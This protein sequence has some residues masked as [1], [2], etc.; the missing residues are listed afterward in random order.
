M[1]TYK[2]IV[3]KKADNDE[4][5]T[6]KYISDKFGKIYAENFRNRLI[7]LFKLLSK[8]PLVGRPAKNDLILRVYTFN[9]QNKLVYKV[10]ATE[11]II[12]RLLNTKK[13]LASMF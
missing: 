8:Y 6:Y 1:I 2:I 12:I 4:E 10:T 13:N 3:T 5:I 11:V 9:N 7:E